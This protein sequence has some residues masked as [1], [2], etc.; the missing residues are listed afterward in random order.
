MTDP[1]MDALLSAIAHSHIGVYPTLPGEKKPVTSE[2][3]LEGVT[4]MVTGEKVPKHVTYGDVMKDHY[5]VRIF[6]V[7]GEPHIFSKTTS[8]ETKDRFTENLNKAT[9]GTATGGTATGVTCEHKVFTLDVST[10]KP[11]M[12]PKPA[13]DESKVDKEKDDTLNVWVN[14]CTVDHKIPEGVTYD[15]F[16]CAYE[17]VENFNNMGCGTATAQWATKPKSD[18]TAGA[19]GMAGDGGEAYGDLD[20]AGSVSSEIYATT[21]L[22]PPTIMSRYIPA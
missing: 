14:Y 1:N 11:S 2:T 16:A 12:K 17:I 7:D 4:R 5:R 8:A 6:I 13:D 19:G 18:P 22:A 3:K 10:G 15:T 21:D 20:D 9:G